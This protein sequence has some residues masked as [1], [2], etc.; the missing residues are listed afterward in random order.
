MTDAKRSLYQL[1]SESFGG[2]PVG[3]FTVFEE[4]DSLKYQLNFAVRGK[5]KQIVLEIRDGQDLRSVYE[6][7]ARPQLATMLKI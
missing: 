3:G 7:E 4:P 6:K 1:A 5:L 2:R